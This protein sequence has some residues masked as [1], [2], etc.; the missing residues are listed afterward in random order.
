M[1]GSDGSSLAVDGELGRGQAAPAE[2]RDLPARA[3]RATCARSAI[4]SLEAAVHKMTGLPA[5]RLGLGDRGV[6]AVGAKADVVGFDP[7]R[8][9]DLATYEDPHRYAAGIPTSSSTAAWSSTAASTPARCPAA[10]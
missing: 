4:L 9:E 2:L 5:R 10:C 6:L 3:R 8:V 7:A 1:I